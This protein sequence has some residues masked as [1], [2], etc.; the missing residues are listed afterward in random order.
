MTARDELR[1]EMVRN[2]LYMTEE[3][4]D[5]LIDAA[6]QEAEHS[7]AADGPPMVPAAALQ[8]LRFM[9]ERCYKRGINDAQ[10]LLGIVEQAIDEHKVREYVDGLGRSELEL[11]TRVEIAEASARELGN[12]VARMRGAGIIDAEGKIAPYVQGV[13]EAA[14]GRVRVLH[15]RSPSGACVHCSANDYPDYEVTHPCATLRALDNLEAS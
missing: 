4:A 12:F 6:L 15:E 1:Q 2:H 11:R 10:Y 9:A 14:T 7:R 8:L 13:H 3:R 5:E